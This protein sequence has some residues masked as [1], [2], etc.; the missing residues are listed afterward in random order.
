MISEA[1]KEMVRITVRFNYDY[2]IKR[3]A[4]EPISVDEM[5]KLADINDF[6]FFLTLKVIESNNYEL[7]KDLVRIFESLET[8]F[9]KIGMLIGSGMF[10]ALAQLLSDKFE[11]TMSPAEKINKEDFIESF[12]RTMRELGMS[13]SQINELVRMVE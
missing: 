7:A 1:L 6:W 11:I 5:R 12:K 13:E 2:Y 10:F 4:R 3:M 8:A 9:L